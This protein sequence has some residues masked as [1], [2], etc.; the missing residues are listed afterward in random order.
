MHIF[1]HVILLL[2]IAALAGAQIASHEECKLSYNL[3]D[4]EL[5]TLRNLETRLEGFD[6]KVFLKLKTLAAQARAEAKK[7]ESKL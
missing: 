5:D 2:V 6:K 3:E 1:F 7:I 4:V